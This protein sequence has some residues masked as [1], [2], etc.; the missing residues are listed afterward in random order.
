[1]IP[2]FGWQSMFLVAFIPLV[3]LVPLGLRFFPETLGAA[4]TAAEDAASA[5]T[6]SEGAPRGGFAG[7]FRNGFGWISVLFAASTLFTLFAWYGLGTQLPKIMR[8]S[9]S[10]LG[11][12][13]TFTIALN[14][15][16]VA[17]SIVTAWAGDKFGTVKVSVIAAALAGIG[18][19]ALIATP[20]SNTAFIYAALVVAGVGTHG[21]QSLVIGAIASHYPSELRGTALGWAL[22]VGRIGAVLAPQLSGLMLATK[23]VPPSM[24]FVMF[25]ASAIVAAVL[26]GA[27]VVRGVRR[28][29]TAT[30][31][32]EQVA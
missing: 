10:D 12:A 31:A 19:V 11:P 24:N 22:G 8:D 30:L 25:G 17:G 29:S 23:A 9:G 21:T 7:L 5:S 3:V 27:I 2:A 13:L 6:A 20:A 1:M 32:V 16:A 4:R 26:L 14:L 15:G 18:L 28:R